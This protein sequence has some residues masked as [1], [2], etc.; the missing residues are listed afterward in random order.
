ARAA[1]E[2]R[3]VIVNDVAQAEDFLPNPLLPDTRAEMALPILAG[4]E[5]LGVIDLQ[6]EARNKFSEE[7][8]LVQNTLSA[9]VAI[10]LQN[11]RSFQQSQQRARQLE[12]VSDVSAELSAVLDRVELVNYAAKRIT[13]AF[14]LYHIHIYVADPAERNLFLAAGNGRAPCQHVG[15]NYIVGITEEVSLVT[16]V[17]RERKPILANDVTREARFLP[18][19]FLPETRSQMVIPMTVGERFIGVVDLQADTYNA[20][21]NEDLVIFSTLTSQLAVSLANAYS[22]EQTQRRAQEMQTVAE[23]SAQIASSLDRDAMLTTV[24]D[25]ARQRFDLYHAHIYLLDDR[26]QRLVLAAGAGEAGRVMVRN[27]HAIS[28]EQP[29]SI[30]AQAAREQRGVI[31]NDVRS[32]QDF[33]P[34]PLLPETKAE[35]A[36]PII[37][38]DA[39]LGVLDVQSSQVNRFTQDDV[40]VKS[41]LAAQIAVSLQNARLF[42]EQRAAQQALLQQATILDNSN[43]FIAL[44]TLEGEVLYLNPGGARMMGFPTPEAAIGSRIQDYHKPEGT[45][46]MLE[47]GVPTILERDIWRTENVLKRLDGVMIPV[48]QTLFLVRDDAGHP[49][50]IGS[51]MIDIT[52][53]KQAEVEQSLLLE[54]AQELNAV[55]TPQELLLAG[56]RFPFLSG[57]TSWGTST[58]SMWTRTASPN[59]PQSRRPTPT[60][61]KAAPARWARAST[62]QTSRWLKSGPPTRKARSSPG[63]CMNTRLLTKQAVPFMPSLVSSPAW[64][65]R[66]IRTGVGWASTSCNRR[67]TRPLRQATS[68]FLPPSC[69]R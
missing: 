13:Q 6:S 40:S 44:T 56:L 4:E 43:D 42:E 24:C 32:S 38:G 19:Q 3:G 25:Q 11:A 18:S 30:V 66:S 61:P 67:I 34:N 1:R 21:S 58:T 35:M 68:A 12:L 49:L 39:L 45:Q 59:G 9:Q 50:N 47:H 52:E 20:F 62:C 57:A 29:R 64:C 69:G 65:S 41:T 28:L 23:L 15:K 14:Q 53:R 48:D 16:T 33:L 63:M 8:I 10:A 5:L 2:R 26:G 54:V 7:D 31:N 37:A 17:A 55:T 36:V 51:I 22:F 27:H 46:L 60:R